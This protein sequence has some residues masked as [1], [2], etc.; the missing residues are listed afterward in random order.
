MVKTVHKAF[1]LIELL[2]II[3]IMALMVS[4]GIVSLQA[5]QDAARVKSAARDVMAA[6][7][8]ARSHALISKRPVVVIYSN[9][10]NGDESCASVV[11]QEKSLFRESRSF[12][13]VYTLAGDRVDT[14]DD[15]A[16]DPDFGETAVEVLNPKEVSRQVMTG[17]KL[18][19]LEEDETL[20]LPENE[21]RRSKISIFSTADNVS[22]TLESGPSKNEK[23]AENAAAEATEEPVKV[24]FAANGT[25]TPPHRVW[26]YPEGSDPSGGFSIHVDRFGEPVCET[27]ED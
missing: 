22:R 7:R 1:T 9:E 26:I 19:V 21:T 5:A 8:T 12:E 13:P 15:V 24:A 18:K 17:L 4:V 6:I 11:I 16:D 23:P 20:M 2:V 25:V 27:K 10:K 3:A 14:G